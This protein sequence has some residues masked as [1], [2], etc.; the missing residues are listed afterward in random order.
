MLA[1]KPAVDCLLAMVAMVDCRRTVDISTL[2]KKLRHASE[3]LVQKTAKI[4]GC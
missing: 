2:H 1:V 3:A 4:Y